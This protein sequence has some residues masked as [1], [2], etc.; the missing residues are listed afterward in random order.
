MW[1]HWMRSR[2]FDSRQ[3]PGNQSIE[4]HVRKRRLRRRMQRGIR[5]L[6]RQQERRRMRDE[7][8]QQR[9]ELRRLRDDLFDEP[10]HPYVHRE[11]V[12]RHVRFGLREL[13]RVARRWMRSGHL[14][15]QLLQRGVRRWPNV[16]RWHVSNRLLHPMH[17]DQREHVRDDHLPRGD[18]SVVNHVRK[19]R[20]PQ[21]YVRFVLDI[22]VPRRE[23]VDD[24][25]ERLP[26]PNVVH[27]ERVQRHLRGSL[28]RHV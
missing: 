25:F 11:R 22:G 17:H 13:Q 14:V 18:Q 4:R 2:L 26:Q 20:H 12:W 5:R 10:H 27:L 7:H 21:R 3:L 9:I 15:W 16:S 6:Q 19:L 8:N 1:L 23:L 24:R 28:F